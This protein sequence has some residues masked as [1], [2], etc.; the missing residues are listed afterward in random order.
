MNYIIGVILLIFATNSFAINQKLIGAAKS[1]EET[2][3]A[4]RALE[5]EHEVKTDSIKDW[6]RELI[7]ESNSFRPSEQSKKFYQQKIDERKTQLQDI[8][9]QITATQALLKKLEPLKKEYDAQIKKGHDRE[10]FISS[11]LYGLGTIGLPLAIIILFGVS[12]FRTNRKYKKMLEEGKIS[13]QEYEKLTKSGAYSSKKHR[14]NPATGLPIFG[15]GTCD[16][17]GNVRG[18]S[19]RSHDYDRDYR[20]KHRWDHHDDLQKWHRR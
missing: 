7:E 5:I 14:T 10:E 19:S 16:V 6:N 3:K 1:Y 15:N 18:S 11:T 2:G 17:S 12:I 4:L 9:T 8:N 13:Q 20:E